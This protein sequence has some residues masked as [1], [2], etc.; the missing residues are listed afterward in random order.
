MAKPEWGTK[1]ICQACGAKFYDLRRSPIV[2]PACGVEFDPEALLRSRR[3]RAPGAK[4]EE[5][6][7]PVVKKPVVKEAAPDKDEE[8]F[9]AD[10]ED[11]ELDDT[12]DLPDEDGDEALIEDASELG[13]DEEDLS[14]VKVKDGDGEER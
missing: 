10:L 3:S 8:A 1:R 14:D 12:E 5:A 9:D 2:C 13:E 11:E 6:K 7:K 4:E